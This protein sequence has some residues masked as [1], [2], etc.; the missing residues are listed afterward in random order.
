MIGNIQDC[1]DLPKQ[2]I[3]SLEHLKDKKEQIG[4]MLH[5]SCNINERA[6]EEKLQNEYE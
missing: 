1:T 5:E 2:I 6:V 3:N 4:S